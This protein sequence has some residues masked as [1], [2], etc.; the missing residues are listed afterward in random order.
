MPIAPILLDCNLAP[1][2]ANQAWSDRLTYAWTDECCGCTAVAPDL[3]NRKAG[4][5]SMKPRINRM[6]AAS[7]PATRP[8]TSSANAARCSRSAANEAAGTTQRESFFNGLQVHGTRYATRHEAI[9]R[10]ERVPQIAHC[11]ENA[12]NW[13][14]REI[15]PW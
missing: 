8:R 14:L 2:P 9:A 15:D 13:F 11:F 4:D 1:S 10:T 7:A 12:P 6:G 3:L 5:R